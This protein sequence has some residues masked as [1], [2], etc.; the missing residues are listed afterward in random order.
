M[1]VVAAE[2]VSDVVLDA[3]KLAVLVGTVLGVQLVAVFQSPEPGLVPHVA[4][5]A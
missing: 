2:K 3:P 4:F 1:D 5:W